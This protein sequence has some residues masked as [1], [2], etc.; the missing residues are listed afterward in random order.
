MSPLAITGIADH[1]GWAIFVTV[2]A[3]K[4]EPII[5]DRRRVP[6]IGAGIPDNPYHH[7]SLELPLRQGEAL[8]ARVKKSAARE[9]VRGLTDLVGDLEGY[10]VA[11][12]A[13]RCGPTV[14]IPTRLAA[15]HAN[16]RALC[17][18]DGELYRRALCRSAEKLGLKIFEHDRRD[19]LREAAASLDSSE[20]ELDK[21]L[22][23]AAKPL[24]SPWTKEHTGAAAAAW[25]T[26][27]QTVISR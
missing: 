18:A 19:P 15:I 16:R 13:I 24:G 17:A 26:L 8:V 22:R 23:A 7:E 10:R 4:A 9:S 5:V 12:M 6:L 1:T 3:R 27:N 2:A 25:A 21:M 11:G 20:I 14:A